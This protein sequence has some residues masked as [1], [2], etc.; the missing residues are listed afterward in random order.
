MNL[1]VY[2]DQHSLPVQPSPPK[3]FRDLAKMGRGMVRTEDR[4]I[5]GR[6]PFVRTNL[7]DYMAR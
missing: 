4:T 2:Q 7:P 1:D 6:D 5:L 3:F